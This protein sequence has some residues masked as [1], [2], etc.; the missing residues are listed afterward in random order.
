MKTSSSRTPTARPTRKK[1][2]ASATA[3]RR[4]VRPAVSKA[5]PAAEVATAVPSED[6]V[7]LRAYEIY[8]RR[9]GQGDPLTDWL[10]AEQELLA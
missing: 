9:G 3:P 6:E 4:R 10:Q 8:V 7:R 5:T 2:T 1:T